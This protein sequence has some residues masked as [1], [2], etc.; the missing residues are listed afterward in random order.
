VELA[1]LVVRIAS[2]T[3]I[4]SLAQVQVAAWLARHA[5]AD[6]TVPA[7]AAAPRTIAASLGYNV[8]RIYKVLGDLNDRGY[9]EW[10]RASGHE[11][12][13]GQSGAIRLLIP[14]QA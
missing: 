14:S 5:S 2:D 9:I 1:N 7:D 10:R 11:R 12:H 4:T 6:Y 13:T 8:S 3:T